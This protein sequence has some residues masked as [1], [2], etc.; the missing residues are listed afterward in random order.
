MII[1]HI[2]M[3]SIRKSS[4]ASLV[5]YITNAQNKQERV[6]HI[7][8]NHCY[9]QTIDW[10]IEEVN[11]VQSQNQ[12]AVGDKVYHL[13]ISFPAG[14]IPSNSN[15]QTIEERAC[16][17]IGF[18]GYQR[19]S[20]LHHDT[21]HYHIHV[22]I[23]KIHPTRFTLHEPYR[24]Y[25]KLADIAMQLE[26]D[27]CLQKTNHIPKKTA[28]Q[29]RADD[30]EHH[31]G[32]ES[33][34]HWVQRHCLASLQQSNNWSDF[35]AVLQQHSLH[36]VERGSG[37]VIHNGAG[38]MIKASSVARDCSRANLEKRLGKFKPVRKTSGAGT[39]WQA[40]PKMAAIGKKPPSYRQHRLTE[41]HDMASLSMEKAYQI[42]PVAM[43]Y[44]AD[45][46][47]RYECDKQRSC[48]I[49]ADALKTARHKKQYAIDKAKRIAHL[50]RKAIKLISNQGVNKKILYALVS[51]GL[52]KDLKQASM[53]YNRQKKAIYT[54]T[55][56]RAWADWLRWQA[57]L[58]DTD[59]LT[60]LR[61]RD[62]KQPLTGNTFSYRDTMAKHSVLSDT[63][64]S[65]TKN[66][67]IIYR[68]GLAVIRDNGDTLAL[69]KEPADATIVTA[70]HLA[71][72]RY[73]SVISVNGSDAF[74]ERVVKL[75]VNEPLLLTFDNA[76]LE[77]RR[78][79]LMT[80]LEDITDEQQR[81]IITQSRRSDKSC[82][83]DARTVQRG[84]S[85]RSK[86]LST[87][88]DVARRNHKPYL[89]RVGQ[90]PPP[91]RRNGLRKLSELSVVQLA[92]RSEMLLPS[93]VSHHME[94]QRAEPDNRLRREIFRSRATI[95]ADSY[96]AERELKRKTIATILPHRH[97]LPEDANQLVQ[98][99]GLRNK[100]GEHL[101][102][103]KH[104]EHIIVMPIDNAI[105]QSLKKVSVGESLTLLSSGTLR[106]NH[107][108]R[109]R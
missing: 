5:K 81:P 14:E 88:A 68:A 91:I 54:L 95:A 13:L 102:L 87:H 53:E 97:Y 96:I 48:G 80:E 7:A 45:L 9:N 24:A 76:I 99:A 65:I 82:D 63:V 75:A 55:K 4:F 58:G 89:K 78:Q 70:L 101:V 35:H 64:D 30:M 93:D 92:N 33:L 56:R 44:K 3:K 25:K 61:S 100:E 31:A 104:H 26:H 77:H 71:I 106:I 98:F 108:A 17:A 11:A 49:R 18:S 19:I 79:S 1:R 66:G 43:R 15:L 59:A 85:T 103:V 38:L 2:P 73:G 42:K 27:F 23:N 41:L 109:K 37:F 62:A 32:I 69:A 46:Y 21:D 72:E 90:C 36:L 12:R 8:I 74:K 39:V 94:Q 29:N 57:S 28:S 52:K 16:A 20:A 47:A 6:G 67:T 84:Y 51:N 83:G 10:A 107:R 86:Y 22:A 34:L 40:K 105:S 50:K 60:A